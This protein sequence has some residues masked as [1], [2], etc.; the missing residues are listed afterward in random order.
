MRLS[1]L[2]CSIVLLAACSHRQGRPDVSDIQVPV[3]IERFDQQFFSI[4]TNQLEASMNKVY[5]QYPAFLGLY[6]EYLS[7]INFIVHQNGKSYAEAVR[8][9]YRNIK[10]LYDATAK[11]FTRLDFVQ[12]GL[13]DNL[14]YVRY[15]FPKYKMPAVFASVESLNPEEPQ[16]IYGTALYHDT[17]IISLQMFLGH[18][19]PSYDPAQYFDY[20]RRRFEPEYIV[21]NSMRAVAADL[22]PDSS[23]EASLIEQFVE[24]GKQWFLLDHIEPDVPDTLKTFMTAR[25]LEWCRS[26]EG[27]IW[28]K[29]VETNPDLYTVDKESIQAWLGEG[30]FSQDLPHE[31]SPGNVGQWIGWRM[32]R[33]FADEHPKLTLQ[34]VLST[35]AKQIFLEAKYK[36]K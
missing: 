15:Y 13:E 24:K 9:Y 1:L 2:L 28:S 33:K 32:V 10:P 18:D 8:E 20:I 25:Q 22:Y 3:K 14:R 23:Q 6:F 21:P 34:E 27:N 31:E 29:V 5:A 30:P 35:P 17:L 11:R 4:D 12:K 7:P 26:N 19:F 36:P 16:E